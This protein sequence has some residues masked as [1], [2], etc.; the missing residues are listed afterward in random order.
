M[1]NLFPFSSSRKECHLLYLEITKF[2][3]LSS[4]LMKQFSTTKHTHIYIKGAT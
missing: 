2:K 1:P 4:P 3:N